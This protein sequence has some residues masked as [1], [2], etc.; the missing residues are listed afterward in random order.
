MPRS[1]TSALAVGAIAA[2]FAGHPAPTPVGLGTALRFETDDTPVFTGD[3]N[4]A[5]F[6]RQVGPHKTV[7]IAHKVRGAWRPAHAAPFSGRWFDQNPELAP[8]GSYLL[9][10][11][12]RPVSPGGRPLVQSYFGRPQPGS[13]IWRVDRRG[14]GWSKP[15]WLGPVVNDAA[16]VDF[17]DVVQDGSLY[18]LKWDRGTV[19]LFRSQYRAGAYLPAVRVAIGDDTVP[20]HDAAV[21]PDESFMI[22]DY[23][24]VKGGLG[25][26]SIAYRVGG[27][28]SRPVDLGNA[29]NA[30]LPWGARLA[31]DHL[32]VYFTG[33]TRI[34]RLALASWAPARGRSTP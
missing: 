20:T 2:A 4:T 27:K 23:G 13:N 33:A 6:D 11:S 3:G 7:M 19:H 16:F 31:P 5:F 17:P 34:W 1:L 10:D 25:R 32:T 29:V 8:D 26:L 9:F 12:D 30:D 14:S 22:F 18:F 21:A 24:R 15:V 28:W